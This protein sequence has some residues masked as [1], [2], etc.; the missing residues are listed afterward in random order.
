MCGTHCE[1]GNKAAPKRATHLALFA[2]HPS[3]GFGLE[4]AV[5]RPRA[6]SKQTLTDFS[7]SGLIIQAVSGL[8]IN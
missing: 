2:L 1:S 8:S 4:G 3:G 7:G 5:E 6:G